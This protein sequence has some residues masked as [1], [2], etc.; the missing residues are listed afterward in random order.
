MYDMCLYMYGLLSYSINILIFTLKLKSVIIYKKV[1]GKMEHCEHE[2]CHCNNQK[3]DKPLLIKIIIS[4]VLFE[5]IAHI[6]HDYEIVFII[7]SYILISY[8]LYI[9]AFKSIIK[10]DIFNENFLM[11]IATIGAFAIGETH[12][13]LMVMILYQTGEFLSSLAL[14]KT[15]KSITELMNLRVETVN[16]KKDNKLS[17]KNVKKVD[18]GEIFIVKKG[19]K[20]PLDGEIIK[21]N[22]IIDTS[23]LTG[24][25]TPKK[26]KEGD[27]ILSG[28]INLGNVIEIKSISKYETSTATKIIHL[29]ENADVK[30]T[31]TEKFI[32]RF[33]RIYT[34]VVVILAISIVLVP[35]L[36]GGSFEDWLYKSLIFLVSSCPCAL[37]I[38]IP[39]SYFCAIGRASKS[40]ILIKGSYELEKLNKIK[41]IVFDKTGTITEGVFEVNEIHNI[42]I[43]KEELLKY[44]CY[45]QHYSNHPIS[46]SLKEK[47]KKEIDEKKIKNFKEYEGQ[48][49]SATIDNKKI[50]IGSAK[51]LEKKK[52]K[53]IT[54]QTYGSQIHISIDKEYKGYIIISDKIKKEMYDLVNELYNLKIQN[55]VI[56]SG[57]NINI[58]SKVSKEVG[59]KEYHA[60]LLPTQ[61]VDI[62]KE[63]KEKGFTAFVGDGINDA[64]VIKLSDIGIAMGKFG[65]DSAVEAADIVLMNDDLLSITKALKLSKIV[66]YTCNFNIIFTLSFKLTVLVLTLFGYTYIWLAVL[67]DVGVTLFTVLMSLRIFIKKL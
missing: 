26:A 56:L 23:N 16:I 17:E 29:I 41:A 30:K 57:D 62:L 28:V 49:V 66:K 65:S 11:I 33:C 38:S 21:G 1:G 36:F 47:Y 39:L 55:L 15:R 14:S 8:D 4:F 13:A 67:A 18:I 52:I 12:E 7:I 63:I 44:A 2:H 48:G 50:I 20:V 60:E 25:S 10:K 27:K 53:C 9:N 54:T 31:I 51:F 59:I 64:P 46:T 3:I 43:E 22:T 34:P 40:G 35:V 37:V 45:A 61:K 42:N 5:F 32:T 24:E 58:V 6:F 19:E